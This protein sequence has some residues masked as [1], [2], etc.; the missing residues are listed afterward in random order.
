[1][2]LTLTSLLA[3][4][5][6]ESQLPLGM[7]ICGAYLWIIC[8]TNPYIRTDDDVLHLL[9]QTEI[10]LLLMVRVAP[11][12][13]L[14]PPARPRTHDLPRLTSDPPLFACPCRPAT[15]STTWTWSLTTPSRTG[16]SA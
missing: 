3:L 5:P 2:Q 16:C 7:I 13:S 4:F 12:P 15:C 11:P 14:T 6:L 1:M 8:R 9:I 10:L